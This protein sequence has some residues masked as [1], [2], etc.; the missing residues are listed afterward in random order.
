MKMIK[1]IFVTVILLLFSV[2]VQ[3]NLIATSQNELQ[4]KEI[5]DELFET[6]LEFSN[7]TEFTKLIDKYDFKHIDINCKEAGIK[8]F[9]RNQ[10]ILIS[11]LLNI[12]EASK[13]YIDFLYNA[14]LKIID[15]IGEKDASSLIC[16]VKF[17]SSEPYNKINDIITNDAEL[18]GEVLTLTD[19]NNNLKSDSP[20]RYRP[21]I[22]AF[23]SVIFLPLL[24]IG[25]FFYVLFSSF[26]GLFPLLKEFFGL[27]I[28]LS[29]SFSLYFLTIFGCIEWPPYL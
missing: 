14:G 2:V 22:C 26:N 19:F 15:N 24:F 11:I 20:L 25:W 29:F 27:F 16:S 17:R 12:P 1:P 13:D 7:N 10:R 18:K 5:K 9:S 3:P 4:E 8:I 6:L 21:I 28:E 23:I